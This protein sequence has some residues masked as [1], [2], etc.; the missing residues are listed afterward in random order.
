VTIES[1]IGVC[2]TALANAKDKEHTMIVSRDVINSN[3]VETDS[4]DLSTLLAA[5]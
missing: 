3:L 2:A 4:E 5:R 1:D